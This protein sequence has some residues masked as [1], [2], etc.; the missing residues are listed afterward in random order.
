MRPIGKRVLVDYKPELNHQ[1]DSG[2]YVPNED[3]FDFLTLKV[4]SAGF[5]CE[6]VKD[7][8]EILIRKESL[9]QADYNVSDKLFFTEENLILKVN[10]NVIKDNLLVVPIVEEVSKGGIIML[11]DNTS[12]T[13]R[14]EV[15]QVGDG[16]ESVKLHDTVLYNKNHALKDGDFEYVK[17]E[18]ILCV[19]NR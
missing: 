12:V 5:K 19:F 10:D 3:A 7:G 1:L 11:E 4:I 14:A 13:N 16:C 6:D 8:D 9:F 15:V 2:L 18:A 17:E